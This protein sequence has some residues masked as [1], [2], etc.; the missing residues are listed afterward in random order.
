VALRA[1]RRAPRSGQLVSISAADPLNLLGTVFPGDR[2]PAL[3]AN[4]IVFEDGVALAVLEAGQVRSLAEYPP[5]RAPAI[6]RA[7]ARRPISPALRALLGMPGRPVADPGERPPR[8]AS[9]SFSIP[10]REE[11]S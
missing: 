3:A 6:E 2:L 10:S 11:S 4:R 8:R 5:D 1:A 9:R 7:L